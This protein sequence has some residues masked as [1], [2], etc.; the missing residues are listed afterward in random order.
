MTIKCQRP[1][2]S[3]IG[4][5]IFETYSETGW[6]PYSY[7]RVLVPYTP[8]TELT[9]GCQFG[10]SGIPVTAW[11]NG[12]FRKFYVRTTARSGHQYTK[13][14]KG[15][16]SIDTNTFEGPYWWGSIS[17]STQYYRDFLSIPNRDWFE[18]SDAES[19]LFRSAAGKCN[20][21]VADQKAMILVTI[22]E[23]QKTLDMIANTA[24]S[25]AAGLLQ[26]KKGDF[27]GAYRTLMHSEPRIGKG[28]VPLGFPRGE[29]PKVGR[30]LASNWLS[31]RYGWT[32]TFLDAIGIAEQTVD[33]LEALT[34][35]NPIWVTENRTF[36]R[37]IISTAHN[38]TGTP[39]GMIDKNTV[40]LDLKLSLWLKGQV[41]D[42]GM[43]NLAEW[44]IPNFASVAW[45]LVPLSFVV[46][47]F[48]PVSDCIAFNTQ[49]I[50]V[51]VSDIGY[52]TI[53]TIQSV[54]E[55]KRDDKLASRYSS[56]DSSPSSVTV[57]YY[58]RAP[59]ELEALRP[60][61]LPRLNLNKSKVLDAV[62][63]FR[64]I[65]FSK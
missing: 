36:Q 44:G 49:Y 42:Y 2:S 30:S 55:K 16:I 11:V 25:F 14:D 7:S 37:K 34:H 6:Y 45:E 10:T 9:G 19:E 4:T 32:P 31:Y 56:Y 59:L 64:S 52:H 65:A 28:G 46:D 43:K 15:T 40:T 20:D 5:K 53:H 26:I 41:S 47:W 17:R 23:S 12:K 18:T 38:A 24:R 13:V 1:Y 29:T 57:R 35:N 27:I 58:N 54:H 63:L 39:V 3:L 62:A 21:K 50:G 33:T 61:L 22:A 48:L 51:K 60:K 8:T